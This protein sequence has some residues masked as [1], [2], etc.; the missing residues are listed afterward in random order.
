MG[1]G[2]KIFKFLGMTAPEEEVQKIVLAA[3]VE[4]KVIA[5]KDV[6]DEAFNCGALGNVCAIE[7]TCGEVYAPCDGVI[8]VIPDTK[9]A[10]GLTGDNG[11][12]VLVHI[13]MNKIG[14]AH[15]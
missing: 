1:F 5:L 8:S 15:V 13:G 3:P 10:I 6:E 7:P 2:Q 9:H 14:R 4:G 12:E 11:A